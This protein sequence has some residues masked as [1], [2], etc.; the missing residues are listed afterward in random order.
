MWSEW[1]RFAPTAEQLLNVI[2]RQKARRFS[3]SDDRN[4]DELAAATGQRPNG[5]RGVPNRPQEISVAA[6]R[7]GA[8]P[9]QDQLQ[10]AASRG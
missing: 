9:V 10:S 5:L 3:P 1:L 8:V 7:L 6:G 2:E 4:L